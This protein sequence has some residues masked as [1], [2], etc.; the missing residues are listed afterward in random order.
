MTRT[1]ALRLLGTND[2]AQRRR[3][4]SEASC[5]PVIVRGR[6]CDSEWG[7]RSAAAL[8]PAAAPAML[9]RLSR[10]D[11]PKARESA[12][13]PSTVPPGDTVAPGRRRVRQHPPPLSLR[14]RPA[15]PR[16]WSGSHPMTPI[17]AAWPRS[18][19]PAPPRRCD[20]SATTVP[21]PCGATPQ[22]TRLAQPRCSAAT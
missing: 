22:R 6:V 13:T 12:A 7:I 20:A 5:P 2:S 9:E 10:D 3:V 17:C 4:M 21:G 18:T 16:R 19:R 15:H 14:T 1:A 8:H 11:H